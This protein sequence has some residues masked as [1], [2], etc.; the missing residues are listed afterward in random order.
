MRRRPEEGADNLGARVALFTVIGLVVLVAGAWIGLYLYAGDEAPRHASVEGV[1]IAGLGPGE[2]EER[3]RTELADRAKE[4]V[5]MSYGDGRSTSIVP[6]EAGMTVDHEA[7]VRKAGGGSGFGPRRMWAVLTGGGD[8]HAE[9]E[10]DQP[11][12]EAVLDGLDDGIRTPPVQGTVE[13]RDGKAVA[14]RSRAGHVV[15]RSAAQDI[16]ERRFLHGG[17]QKI[18]TRSQEPEITDADV[19]RALEEFGRPAM[20]GPV[21]IDF[22]GEEVEA[23]PRLFGKGLSMEVED[24]ELVPRVDGEKL[25][26]ALAP[27]MRTVGREPKDA[28]FEVVRGKPRVVPAKVGVELDPEQ[29]EDEFADVASAEGDERR[30]EVDG[31]RVQPEFTTSDAKKLGIKERVSSFTT[32]FPYAEYRNVNLTRAAELIDGTVLQPG[33]TF[34]LNET[35]GERT[36]ENGFTEGYVVSDGIF[37]K[38]LGGGVSQIATTTF[39]AM[40]FAGLKDIEHKPHSVYIDRY[41]AGREATVAWPSVDLRFEND[42]PHGVLI[43]ARVRKAAP[44]G[45]GAATVSMYSTKR[46]DIRAVAGPRTDFRQPQ[47]RY[48]QDADCEEFSGT[49]GFSINV[50]RHFRDLDS[51]KVQR[52]ERFHT[53]YIAG[54]TVRCG[55]PPKP[56]N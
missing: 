56:G 8:H 24:G 13:F 38:D 25:L 50:F 42:S 55:P 36:A 27:V 2:A 47:T 54:D 52:K 40:F 43:K 21:T 35:V 44:G 11:K 22:A 7:S 19:R 34:S 53:D 26:A 10:V 17:S 15:D 28:G 51:G 14:V 45:Q 49:Q 23:P 18:P 4:P 30:L 20:S 39:N 12:M 48:L 1:S 41:P 16:L 33:D 46:W 3:L 37:K 6:S 31:R 32:N 9:L 29:L 5:A